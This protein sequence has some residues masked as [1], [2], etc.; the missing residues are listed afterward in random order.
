MSGREGAVILEKI[1][2]LYRLRLL[3]LR[4]DKLKRSH[5]KPT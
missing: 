3:R 1:A 2:R 5:Q 4:F